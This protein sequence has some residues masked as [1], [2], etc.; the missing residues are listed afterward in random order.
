MTCKKQR[1]K[2]FDNTQ[3]DLRHYH[4]I[5]MPFHEPGCLVKC[6]FNSPKTLSVLPYLSPRRSPWIIRLSLNPLFDFPKLNHKRQKT[7]TR[8]ANLQKNIVL[9]ILLILLLLP[10]P[11]NERTSDHSIWMSP[12][13]CR[14]LR[15]PLVVTRFG[16]QVYD[17]NVRFC[18]GP[19]IGQNNSWKYNSFSWIMSVLWAP[20][21]SVLGLLWECGAY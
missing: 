16:M 14:D 2:C 5:Q 12:F 15:D 13:E 9:E 1:K 4:I 6:F 17:A 7:E 11:N 19:W 21:C 20:C 10:H 3:N 18:S 8:E